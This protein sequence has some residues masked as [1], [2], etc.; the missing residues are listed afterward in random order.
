[1]PTA[2]RDLIL[3]TPVGKVHVLDVRLRPCR[4][5]PFVLGAQSL[6]NLP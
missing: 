4:C 6:V 3:Q 2:K 1:M 5:R